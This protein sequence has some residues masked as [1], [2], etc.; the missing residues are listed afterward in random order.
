[1]KFFIRYLLVLILLSNLVCGDLDEWRL[2]KQKYGD[3]SILRSGLENE[4]QRYQAFLA[5]Y[6]KIKDHNEKYYKNQTTYELALNQFADRTENELFDS[7]YISL[8]PEQLNSN[9]K[10]AMRTKLKKSS[11]RK[12][13]VNWAITGH[14][15]PV[16]NQ[17]SK[18]GACYAFATVKNLKNLNRF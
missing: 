6:K 3:K 5:N 2:W 17:S 4:K 12:D 16:P 18:C 15:A 13:A 1:M 8:N 9:I 11:S 14:L 7:F 10:L